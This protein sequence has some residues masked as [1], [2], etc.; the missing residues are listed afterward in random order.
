MG[1][2]RVR[3]CA[4]ADET[5]SCQQ[6]VLQD[7]RLL[8]SLI[9]RGRL[10]DA[11]PRIGAELEMFLVDR[12]GD[13]APLAPVL[14]ERLDPKSFGAEVGRFNLEANLDVQQL[15][16]S[17]FTGLEQETRTLLQRALSAAHREGAR[18]AL[19]GILPSI[20]HRHLRPDWMTA[21]ERFRLLEEATL[22]AACGEVHLAIRGIDNL[23]LRLDNMML[24]SAPTSFQVHLQVSSDA[25][26]STYNAAQLALGPVLAVAAHSPLFLGRRLWHETRI[27]LIEAAASFRT[28]PEERRGS[29]G[30]V[31]FGTGWVRD[32]VLELFRED[33]LR[34]EPILCA[35]GASEDDPLALTHLS[36]FNGTIWRWNRPCYGLLD[37]EPRLRIECRA[38]PA[39]PTVADQVANAAFFIGL[40][41]GLVAEWGDVGE[42]MRFDVARANFY[43]AARRG[44]EARLRWLDGEWHSADEL[45]AE[46]LLPLAREGLVSAGVSERDIDRYLANLA[47]RVETGRTGA[48]WLLENA[49][50]LE[51][52]P[53]RD[54]LLSIALAARALSPLPIASWPMLDVTTPADRDGPIELLVRSDL[55]TLRPSDALA[56]ARELL[57][58]QPI[59]VVEHADGTF[60]GVITRDALLRDLHREADAAL[61]PSWP[62]VP[63]ELPMT[64]ALA[65][66]H[67]RGLP[68]LVVVDAQGRVFGTVRRSALERWL[69]IGPRMQP[70]W[71][72]SPG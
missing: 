47:Q 59:A 27:P 20:G 54:R 4:T 35:D 71:G 56:R 48:R 7:L 5:R 50:R 29:G 8:E 52:R 46:Q 3:R 13:P 45:I 15:K 25:F 30:R 37:G 44:L 17:C 55:P 60:A 6:A 26:A 12:F 16:G 70:E 18:L 32:S 57:R 69:A 10:V 49:D 33:F 43:E 31:G 41:L 23:E 11:Q 58:D 38:L 62:V 72:G 63:L 22:A 65:L 66:V 36:T 28:L 9:D 19:A 1:T 39:G 42:R 14:L 24:E 51:G 68:A 67:A 34:H 53:D 2:A 61:D 40:T 64:D 21:S